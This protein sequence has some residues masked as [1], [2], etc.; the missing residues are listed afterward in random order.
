MVAE[1]PFGLLKLFVEG[2][3]FGTFSLEPEHYPAGAPTRKLNLKQLAHA[4]LVGWK[5]QSFS[6]R[7]VVDLYAYVYGGV[8]SS[9]P[10]G[11]G[12]HF[13]LLQ[14]DQ[15]VSFAGQPQSAKAMGSLIRVLVKGLTPL[16]DHVFAKQGLSEHRASGTAHPA[17]DVAPV[18]RGAGAEEGEVK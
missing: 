2:M 12:P 5:S 8:H 6:V 16:A 4:P 10:S 9:R 13:P 3:Q 11:Q 7:Q 14:A 18:Q 17:P 15:A 1:A